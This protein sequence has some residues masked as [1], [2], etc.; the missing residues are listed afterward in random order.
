MRGKV[1]L[2]SMAE[3]QSDWKTRRQLVTGTARERIGRLDPNP[4]ERHARTVRRKFDCA[5]V[6]LHLLRRRRKQERGRPASVA[7]G[8]AEG[9][10]GQKWTQHREAMKRA[11]DP[12]I[13]LRLGLVRSASPCELDVWRNVRTARC[14]SVLAGTLLVCRRLQRLRRAYV[15]AEIQQHVARM[16]FDVGT[17]CRIRANLGKAQARA[18]K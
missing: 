9:S 18:V 14:V 11:R 10:L 3:L 8:L 1:C 7:R 5:R 2:N 16:R 12:T 6:G 13:D 4:I 17:Q 15:V